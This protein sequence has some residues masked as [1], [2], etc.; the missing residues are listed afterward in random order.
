MASAE[1]HSMNAHPLRQHQGFGLRPVALAAALLLAVGSL[2]AQQAPAGSPTDVR[3]TPVAPGDAKLTPRTDD[4]ND[5]SAVLRGERGGIDY[6]ANAAVGRVI[7]EVDRD[8]APADGQSPVKVKLMLQGRDG[9]PLQGTAYAT[10]E[11]SGGRVLLPG[12]RTD[13]FG[14]RRADADKST[15][16]VQIKV[17]Q[18]E[19]E[20]TLLAPAEAQDVRLRVTA[21]DQQAAGTI[22]FVPELRPMVAA[23]LA[24]GIVSLHNRASVQPVRR[25]DAF[26]Q[27]IERWSRDFNGGKANI[28]SRASVYLKGTIRGDMLLTLAFDSDK[29]TRAR[30]LRDVKPDEFYPVYGDA[31]LRSFDARSADRLY[32][33]VDKNKSYILYGDFVTGD[34]FSQPIGQGAVASLKSRSLGQYNR[35]A[36]GVRGHHETEGFT[37]NA[38]AINDSLRQ[39]VEEFASQGSGPY[40]LRN[41]A[42]LEGSEKVEVVVRDRNQPSR[43]VAVRPLLR[44]IDYTFEPFSGRILLSTFLPS[45]DENLNPVSLRVTYE[46]DQGGDKFWVGG[47][48]GQFALTKS[49]EVGGSL[50]KDT[51]DLAPYQLASANATWRIAERSVLVAEVAQSKSTVNTNPANQNTSP[52]LSGA[53]GD[54]EGKAARVEFVHEGERTDARLFAGRSSP[55]FDNPAAPLAG[56]R[57]ELHARGGVKI[58]DDVKVYAEGYRSE[59]RNANGGDRAAAGV[60]LEWKATQRLTVDLSLRRSTETIGVQNTGYLISPFS[61]TTGLT[62]SI[63]TGAAGGAVGFGQQAIDPATGVPVIQ[64]GSLAPATSSLPIG[65]ELQSTGV[66]LGASYQ[67]SDRWRLGAQVEADVS[68]DERKRAAIGADYQIAER[69]RLY[70]RY[71]RQRGWVTLGGV[72]DVDRSAGQFALGVE[73]S[74][75]RD[76][77]LFS[78]YRLR[79]AVAGRD[80]QLASGVRHTWDIAEGWRANAA[81]EHLDVFSGDAAPATAVSFGIDW[82]ADPLW[83]AS[84]KLEYRRSGDIASTPSDDR[85]DTTLLQVMAARKLDRDWTLLG[86]HYLL[87]TDYAA[88]GDVLQNRSQLGVAYRD[89]DRN[90]INALGKIEYKQER[91]ASNASVGELSSRAWIAS[92]HAD[93]HPSRPWWFT[94]RVAA[95]WQNDRF[96]NGV[97]DSF[98][99]QLLSGRMVYDI[100]E[101]WDIG[102]LAAAQLG[103]HGARQHALGVEVGYLLAQNLWLSGGFNVT[104]FKGDAD[105]SG[106]EYTRSG[107]YLRLRFKFDENLFRSGDREVNRSLDR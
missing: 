43:I 10:I 35:T 42:V 67:I 24:E 79:D 70:G 26:E 8:A 93:W 48:D 7:V 100:T 97:R 69:T 56:G 105:L 11:H 60:G 23:G 6:A 72:S 102:A 66:R 87:S 59:D 64:Q 82:S 50:V 85:F 21:G 41:N 57:D 31:S 63:A 17:E 107:A 91:D 71:E 95:K 104:G 9:K 62:G 30:L 5:K 39:V 19:A 53:S 94:G 75:W 36:T 49:L 27:E 99:A 65:T 89:T 90:R 38:F 4:D 14:P 12:A 86:R 76:T 33:R 103:Q 20:F 88:R 13:E 47:V 80:L 54:V 81:A 98:R 51:N 101:R 74:Y 34:G 32:V 18:G 25:G 22:S 83:R 84:T 45:V 3:F 55:T 58:V 40:G 15:P 106:Y 44:L 61:S 16:G 37:G 77:Q 2:H 68:G 92:T 73:S 1:L 29:E 28:A 46:V 52:G 96:E 78:E